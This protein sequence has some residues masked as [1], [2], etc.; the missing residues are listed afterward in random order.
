MNTIRIVVVASRPEHGQDGI[1]HI[2][3]KEYDATLDER[4]YATF[5]CPEFGGQ[6][7]LSPSEWREKGE[8]KP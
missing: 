3:G 7:R 5:D 4:Q 8:G 6:I 2:I 1:E